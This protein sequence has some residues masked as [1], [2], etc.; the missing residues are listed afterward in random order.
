VIGAGYCDHD[1]RCSDIQQW[2]YDAIE[3]NVRKR[4]VVLHGTDDHVVRSSEGDLIA[5]GLCAAV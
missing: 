5:K 1:R 4:I 2:D 3:S